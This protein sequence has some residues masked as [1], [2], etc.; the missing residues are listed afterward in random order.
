M[1]KWEEYDNMK[2]CVDDYMV[3]LSAYGRNLTRTEARKEIIHKIPMEKAYQ[4]KIIKYL[5]T[6]PNCKAWKENMGTYGSTSGIPD[7]TA[8]ISGVYYG[9]EVKR[10]LVGKLSDIQE[11]TIKE[12]RAKGAHAYVVVTVEEVKKILRDNGVEAK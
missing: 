10:P 11:A 8:I 7:V 1:K 9:F 6:V 3:K 2:E 4:K 5:E 12:L